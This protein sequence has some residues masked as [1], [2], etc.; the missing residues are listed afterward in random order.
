[1]ATV[2]VGGR[3]GSAQITLSREPATMLGLG[4][5]EHRE[6]TCSFGQQPQLNS[7]LTANVSCQMTKWDLR[8]FSPTFSLLFQPTRW[9]GE[10]AVPHKLCLIADMSNINAVTSAVRSWGLLLSGSE[11]ERAHIHNLTEKWLDTVLCDHALKSY[12]Y[13]SKLTSKQVA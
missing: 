5:S 11:V 6:T 8:W 12:C 2:V 3:G 4:F 9:W 1:M 10:Q 7:L 13:V